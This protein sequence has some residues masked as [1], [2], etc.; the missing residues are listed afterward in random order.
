MSNAAQKRGG[1]PVGFVTELDGIEA[2]S[3]IYL[4]LWSDGADSRDNVWGDFAA[5]LGVEQGRK[6]LTSFENL[7][8]LCSKFGRRP[9]M[10]HAVNCKCLGADESCFANFIGT[11]VTGDRDDA[12]LIATLL[13]RADVAPLLTS[14]ATDFGL[15]LKRMNLRAPRHLAG[16][17][18]AMHTP[19]T[20]LH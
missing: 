16:E 4:R 2:A 10:R 15:A 6:A 3:V 12:M 9:L 1:A 18:H 7:C 20:T 17:D 14:L 8:S 13:V 11:A 5:S 19:P